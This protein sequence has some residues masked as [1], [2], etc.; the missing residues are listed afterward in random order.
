MCKWL[1][2]GVALCISISAEVGR[3]RSISW[4]VVRLASTKLSLSVSAFCWSSDRIEGSLP[5][6]LNN[7]REVLNSLMGTP[8]LQ[9]ASGM[10]EF[11]SAA[12]RKIVG[13]GLFDKASGLPQFLVSSYSFQATGTE[14]AAKPWA[15]QS[16]KCFHSL[17]F[18]CAG[19]QQGLGKWL[20][21]LLDIVARLAPYCSRLY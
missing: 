3:E 1:E 18:T 10:S 14:C 13:K 15:W 5:K 8:C 16:L 4:A 2:V 19:G 21:N 20:R 7:R 11:Q 17:T 6:I 12:L 9:R